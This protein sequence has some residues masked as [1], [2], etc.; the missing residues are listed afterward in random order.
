MSAAEL[1]RLKTERCEGRCWQVF[2]TAG[3]VSVEHE[4]REGEPIPATFVYMP[5]ESGEVVRY[6]ADP[7]D[8][9]AI[10]GGT[11][12]LGDAVTLHPPIPAG[13]ESAER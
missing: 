6:E 10:H 12:R 1:Y 7:V 4:L 13:P 2:A 8:I 5:G 9:L 11:L 3:A